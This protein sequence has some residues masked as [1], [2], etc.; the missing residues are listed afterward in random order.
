VLEGET[1]GRRDGIWG[2]K[3]KWREA[4]FLKSCLLPFGLNLTTTTTT[5]TT[6]ATGTNYDTNTRSVQTPTTDLPFHPSN[7]FLPPQF[8]QNPGGGHMEHMNNITNPGNPFH[9]TYSRH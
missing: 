6:T 7:S 1:I 3:K 8:A 9:P 4:Q 2:R 5:T